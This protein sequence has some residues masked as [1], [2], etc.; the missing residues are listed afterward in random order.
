[1]YFL[2]LT[3]YSI[4]PKRL[5]KVFLLKLLICGKTNVSHNAASRY[6]QKNSTSLLVPVQI[7]LEAPV[8][9]P[10]TFSR[11]NRVISAH[12]A[13]IFYMGTIMFI[14]AS[15]TTS[16]DALL[17]TATLDIIHPNGKGFVSWTKV[18]HMEGP[19]KVQHLTDNCSLPQAPMIITDCSP[20]VVIIYFNTTLVRW[21]WS[22]QTYFQICKKSVFSIGRE[23]SHRPK[24]E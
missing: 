14:P 6:W 10:F 8:D 16:S 19:R 24:C 20:F 3:K 9:Q 23:V 1:M 12:N 22:T 2:C 5:L 21:I 17:I 4:R 13:C 15:V 18:T 11:W 7:P